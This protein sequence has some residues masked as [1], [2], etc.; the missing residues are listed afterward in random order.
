M[1]PIR[2]TPVDDDVRRKEFRGF[3]VDLEPSC[4]RLQ[5]RFDYISRKY[6]YAVGFRKARIG[7]SGRTEGREREGDK[8]TPLT[9]RSR[10]SRRGS[11]L[12]LTSTQEDGKKQR[13]RD[14]RIKEKEGK[15]ERKKTF[16]LLVPK[17]SDDDASRARFLLK[18]KYSGA[19]VV[20]GE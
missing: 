16:S 9:T 17:Q 8:V 11:G 5:F 20:F 6:R 4:R 1:R 13:D 3:G 18:R 2:P 10:N 15:K 19:V 12:N 7:T 14:R